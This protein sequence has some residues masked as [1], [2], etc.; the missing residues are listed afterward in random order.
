MVWATGEV[1]DSSIL[2]SNAP[3][4]QQKSIRSTAIKRSGMAFPLAK[5]VVC[6]ERREPSPDG[7]RG[8]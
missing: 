4:R 2:M 5:L 8:I 1:Y 6:V 7:S 3:A